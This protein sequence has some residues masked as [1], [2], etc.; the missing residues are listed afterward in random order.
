MTVGTNT[1]TFVPKHSGSGNFGN[2][3]FFVDNNPAPG[4]VG[5]DFE[6]VLDTFSDNGTS[7]YK[8]SGL[9]AGVTY[10]VQYFQSDDR[11]SHKDVT[12][13]VEGTNDT[14]DTEIATYD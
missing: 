11:N 13:S 3:S 10:Y 1:I 6:S 8:F 7:S 12:Y 5:A 14:E 2:D 9:T 4:D